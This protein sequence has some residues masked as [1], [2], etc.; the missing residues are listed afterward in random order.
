[1]AMILLLYASLGHRTRWWAPIVTGSL[2]A[3]WGLGFVGW[4]GYNFDPVMLVIPFILTARDMSHGI[5]W[6]GRYYN[7]LDRLDRDKFRAITATTTDMLPPGLLAILADIAG[8]IF[9]SFGGIPVLNHV[10]L[11]GSVW[12][13]GSLTM[14]FIFQPI[15]MSYLP[16]PREKR[17]SDRVGKPWISKTIDKLVAFPTSTGFGRQAAMLAVVLFILGGVVSGLR[18]KVG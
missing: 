17:P 18:A 1:M 14:V 11:A 8:I 10:A 9:I 16:T 4:M 5:Q 7:E 6:Q 15:L 12:L 13:A 3:V 2:S